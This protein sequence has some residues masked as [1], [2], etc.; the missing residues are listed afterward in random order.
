MDTHSMAFSRVCL[1]FTAAKMTCHFSDTPFASLNT[2]LFLDKCYS[3]RA[4]RSQ[5]FSLCSIQKLPVQT[6]P[7]QHV[8][9]TGRQT[10]FNILLS[11]LSREHGFKVITLLLQYILNYT[12]LC[13]CRRC[14]HVRL[15]YPLVQPCFFFFCYLILQYTELY[16]HCSF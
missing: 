7:Q 8:A 13:V 11:F 2:F 12:L 14:R 15:I 1:R 4:A 3:N 10:H 16:L 9:D 6:G 5:I